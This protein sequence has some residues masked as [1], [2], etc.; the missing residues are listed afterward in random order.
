MKAQK[1]FLR[2]TP[3]L[4]AL[5]LSGVAVAFGVAALPTGSQDGAAAGSDVAAVNP[6]ELTSIG[7]VEPGPGGT[8][9]VADPQAA[10]IYALELGSGGDEATSAEYR[11]EDLDGKI[12]DR[13]GTSPR[14]VFVQDMAVHPKTGVAYLSVTRGEGEA[15]VPMLLRVT[16]QGEI[17]EVPPTTPH[18][19]L[20]LQNAPAEDAKMYRWSARTLTVTDMEWIDGELWIAGLSNEEFASQL[21]RAPYPFTGEVASTGLE[22]YHG[23]H[24]EYETF[25]PIYAFMPFELDGEPHIVAS[26]LCTPLVTFP[27]EDLKTKSKLRGKTIAELGFG[28]LPIDMLAVEHEGEEIVLLTNTRR[29]AMRISADDIRAAQKRDGITT[30]VGPRTGVDYITPPLGAVVQ[31]AN[32]DPGHVLTLGR[33]L[34]NGSLYL[35]A[36]DKGML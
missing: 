10:T 2:P 5:A 35:V 20:K 24:G 28:N 12:A 4:L 36:L 27:V 11:I 18:T 21:R 7:V 6:F 23:A 15:A 34:E 25:A 17:S 32:L 33:A 30:E 16:P 29:G 8:L 19:K 14:D 1:T 9:F 26:Y 31:V 13:L 3:I 22:I